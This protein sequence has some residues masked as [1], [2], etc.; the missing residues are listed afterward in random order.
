MKTYFD[1]ITEAKDPNKRLGKASIEELRYRLEI[2]DDAK[3]IAELKSF[4]ADPRIG[5]IRSSPIVLWHLK[6]LYD[7]HSHERDPHNRRAA[8]ALKKDLEGYL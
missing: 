7:I 1:L 4:L 2:A 8:L 3:E 5:R 6:D